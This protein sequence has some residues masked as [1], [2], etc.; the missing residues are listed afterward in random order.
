MDGILTPSEFLTR[1]YRTAIDLE[2]TPLPV[3]MEMEDV[4]A[5][6]RDPI[7]VTVINPT[8]DKGVMV[9]AR[10]AEGT[11]ACGGRILRC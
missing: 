3:P 5:E 11:E 6:E 10:L 1:Y 2:S 7:F 4:V 8:P 9:V